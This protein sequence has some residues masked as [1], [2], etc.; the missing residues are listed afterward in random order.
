MKPI[1]MIAWFSEDG[2]PTPV[3]FN[4]QQKDE[5]TLTIRIDR[6]TVKREEK[7]AGNRI[8]VFTCQ[9]TINGTETIYEIKYELTTCRWFLYKI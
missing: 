4:I 5:S 7:L 8:L 1:K 3:R 9:S 6:I 2:V